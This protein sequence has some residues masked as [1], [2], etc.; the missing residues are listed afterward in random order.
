MP[1]NIGYGPLLLCYRF[2]SKL[3]WR[4]KV[5]E[6]LVR[7][8]DL[9]TVARL[10]TRARLHGRS[11]QKEIKLI[12]EESTPVDVRQAAKLMKLW[13]ERLAGRPF[14][15]SAEQLR[16]DRELCNSLAGTEIA[17]HVTWIEDIP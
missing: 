1:R 17:D 16:Q 9:D 2:D 15:D 7:D 4:P 6:I 5:A 12:L 14:T 8:L 11:L 3:L 10:K 13:Q